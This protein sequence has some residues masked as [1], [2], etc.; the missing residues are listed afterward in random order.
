MDI[1]FNKIV[2]PLTLLDAH[3]LATILLSTLL[4]KC[5]TQNQ[6]FGTILAFERYL[7]QTKL[8]FDKAMID[9]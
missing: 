2:F 7:L 9:W 6:A 8:H 1:D 4:V 3:L 5:Y